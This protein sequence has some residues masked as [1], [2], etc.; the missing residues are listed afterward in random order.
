VSV[1]LVTPPASI[2][3]AV[4]ERLLAQGDEVR[5]VGDGIG[6]QEWRRLGAHVATG[7]PDADLIER[8]GQGARTVVVFDEP[9]PEV[10]EAARAARI[11][12]LVSVTQRLT[13]QA[14]S[15][16]DASGLSYVLLLWRKRTLR[17]ISSKDIAEAVDAAD[18]LA[19]DVKLELDLTDPNA[20]G[21]LGIE[22]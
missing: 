6:S 20:W 12:R 16:L 4:I 15:E 2:G 13:P 17:Q 8:A 19:G 3:S 5:V 18:D 22:R 10:I 21:A 9:Y 1:L 11:E 14:K 7:D